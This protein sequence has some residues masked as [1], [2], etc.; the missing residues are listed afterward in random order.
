MKVRHVHVYIDTNMQYT[1]HEHAEQRSFPSTSPHCGLASLANKVA[2]IISRSLTM[3]E[4]KRVVV[5]ICGFGRAGKIHFR[6]I[7]KNQ[8]CNLK[9][10]VDRLDIEE[11]KATI[12]ATLEK[13]MVEGVQLV[14]AEAFEE[15]CCYIDIYIHNTIIIW[16]LLRVVYY[17][18]HYSL[19]SFLVVLVIICKN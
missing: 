3:S 1:T 5:S 4:K 12:C 17:T 9:Y 13:Y 8:Y 19:T 14:D 16:K 15:V 11:V 18:Q 6:G 10:I 7:L 2:V